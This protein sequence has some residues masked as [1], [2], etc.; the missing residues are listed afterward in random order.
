MNPRQRGDAFSCNDLGYLYETGK[1]VKADR[2]RANEYYERGWR[3]T[4]FRARVA[5]SSMRS[6]P[7]ATCSSASLRAA[8]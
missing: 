8:T 3:T 4:T 1:G 2:S 6:M 7:L 5:D